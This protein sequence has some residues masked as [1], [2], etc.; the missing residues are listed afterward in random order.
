MLSFKIGKHIIELPLS[1][2][3]SQNLRLYPD[4]NSNLP[5]IIKYAAHVYPE[6]KVIDIG[7]NIG[8]TVIFIKNVID[9]PILCID[10]EEKYLQ[11]LKKNTKQFDNVT[12]C[13]SLV[14]METKEKNLKLVMDRGTAQVVESD[15]KIKVRTLDNILLE[16]PFFSDSKILK[17]DTDG[18]DTL[19]LRGCKDFLKK[20]KPILFF[21][22]DPYLISQNKDNPFEFIQYLEECDYKYLIFYVNNGDFL[23][24]CDIDQRGLIDQIIHYFSGRYINAFADIC[25]FTEEDKLMFDNCVMEEIAYF[26]KSRKY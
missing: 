15:I 17:I 1:H 7:A 21:E 16:F 19:I 12:L 3:L 25:A 11:L 13:H 5:R 24:S 14:G 2:Q 4:Y 20:I 22:F 8:D 10:G 26:K 18:F 23:L 9:V 6:I